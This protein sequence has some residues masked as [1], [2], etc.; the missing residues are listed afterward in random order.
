MVKKVSEAPEG[1]KI[2]AVLYFISALA[3]MLIGMFAFSFADSAKTIDP[4]MLTMAG[5]ILPSSGIIVFIGLVFVAISI[6][7]YFLAKGLLAAK[8][9]AKITVGI[10]VSLS[11]VLGIK[12]IFNGIYFGSLSS[13]I[14]SGL[15]LWYLFFKESTKKFFK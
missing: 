15:I 7:C 14:V 2:L 9:W 10:V 4:S 13:I 1:I 12:S 6:L 5:I 3:I 11:I 8:L